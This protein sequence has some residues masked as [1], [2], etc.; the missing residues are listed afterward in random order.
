MDPD[1]FADLSLLGGARRVAREEGS[2]TALPMWIEFMREALAGAPDHVLAKPP[3]LVTV[4]ISPETGTLAS[5]GEL[6]AIF[7]T[8]RVGHVPELAQDAAESPYEQPEEEE[9]ILF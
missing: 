8:F 3:G 6:G 2:R 7:E 4:R 5:S 1:K 9:E